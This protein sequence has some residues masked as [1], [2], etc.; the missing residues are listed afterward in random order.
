M[1]KRDLYP[2]LCGKIR[3]KFRTQGNLARAVGMSPSTLSA[4]LA[5]KTQWSFADVEKISRILEIPMADAPIFFTP[6]VARLQQNDF[7]TNVD[8][9]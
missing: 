6:D 5:G 3:E 1:G 9:Q 7:I 4:K 8:K 2:A